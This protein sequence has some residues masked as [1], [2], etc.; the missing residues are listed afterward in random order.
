VLVIIQRVVQAVR[1]VTH[2]YQAIVVAKLI[3]L[4]TNLYYTQLITVL[5]VTPAVLLVIMLE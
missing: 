4:Q 5:C 2:I 1:L 3:V